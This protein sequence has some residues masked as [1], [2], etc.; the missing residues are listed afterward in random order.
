MSEPK[1]FTK[2]YVNADDTIT[3]DYGDSVKNKLY[4]R[5]VDSKYISSGANS[6]ATRVTLEVV[7]NEGSTAV[8]RTIDY[9][10][11]H[12]HNL[13]AW[14]FYTWNG[15]SWDLVH[16]E[17]VDADDTHIASF[18]EVTVSKVKLEM[19][20]TQSANQ[21]KEIGEFI[22]C[23]VKYETS[24]PDDFTKYQQKWTEKA[25]MLKMIDG[26]NHKVYERITANRIQRYE[27]NCEFKFVSQTFYDTL[28]SLKEEGVPFLFQPESI[29]RKN[30]VYY[31]HWVN[32]FNAQYADFN[33]GAGYKITIQLRE[34]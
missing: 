17:T 30:E 16:S 19:D 29:Q 25:K 34:V 7:F 2:N 9:F 11:I 21:E 31:V 6:D 23:K 18:S 4:D 33:K 5:D 12:K 26:S 13:K 8:N 28:K 20:S 14:R 24:D 32:A 3:V 22:V 10:M 27:A 15:S 1:F